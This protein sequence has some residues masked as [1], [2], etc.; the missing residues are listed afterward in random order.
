M[1]GTR[2]S[3][4]PEPGTGA[5]AQIYLAMGNSILS[6]SI[7]ETLQL[8]VLDPDFTYILKVIFPRQEHRRRGPW[9]RH[10]SV[11]EWCSVTNEI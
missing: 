9:G 4:E 8:I 2:G 6:T 10:Y 1:E 5:V 3:E 7:V 11:S